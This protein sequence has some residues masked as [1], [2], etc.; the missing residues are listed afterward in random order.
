[1]TRRIPEKK[2]K[3]SASY[4]QFNILF[5]SSTI[6]LSV[7]P[8]NPTIY[9]FPYPIPIHSILNTF[10][11]LILWL[12][13]IPISSHFQKPAYCPLPPSVLL[14]SSMSSWEKISSICS[15]LFLYQLTIPLAILL[16]H[17]SIQATVCSFSSTSYNPSICPLLSAHLHSS[18]PTFSLCLH[19]CTSMLKP[20]KYRRCTFLERQYALFLWKHYYTFSKTLPLRLSE[21]EML[22]LYFSLHSF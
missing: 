17:L 8:S 18:S 1:M 2:K 12:L 9:L 5:P 21:S 15:P 6:L 13:T 11:F 3:K 16:Y 19:L 7:H 20:C 14:T 4:S 22:H 10:L